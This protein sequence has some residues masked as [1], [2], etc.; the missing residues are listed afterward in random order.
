MADGNTIVRERQLV[1]RREMDR[2]GISLKAVSLDS[3][4][5]YPTIV[6]YFPGE[7]D[8][9]P[10]TLSGGALFS[11]CSTKALP[12]DLLSLVLPDGFQIVHAPEG[13]DH[14][15]LAT[16]AADYLAVKNA[17]HDPNSECAEAIGPREQALLDGKVAQF[18]RMAA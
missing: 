10:A 18:P 4:I 15:A 3:G 12:L 9:V 14:G 6:S 8:K 16:W 17:A 7:K 1:I 13:I 2:R 11:L 5:P